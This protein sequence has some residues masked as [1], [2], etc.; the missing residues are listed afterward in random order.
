[1][2]NKI[3]RTSIFKKTLPFSLSSPSGNHIRDLL[4]KNFPELCKYIK[5]KVIQLYMKHLLMAQT[6]ESACNA[7]DSG[8]IPESRKSPGEGHGN[9]L[10]YS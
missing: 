1:M 10:Q 2:E 8:S 7:G 4:A 6:V 3:R 9:P 5:L